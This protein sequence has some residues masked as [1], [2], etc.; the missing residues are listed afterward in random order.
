MEPASFYWFSPAPPTCQ[1]A[2]V[3]ELKSLSRMSGWFFPRN[4]RK[5]KAGPSS[6]SESGRLFEGKLLVSKV[7]THLGYDPYVAFPDT[8]NILA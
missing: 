3:G 7:T 2:G 6:P 8:R 1:A 4:T 5:K